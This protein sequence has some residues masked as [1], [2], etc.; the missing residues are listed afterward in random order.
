MGIGR[1]DVL[2]IA[3]LA[4]I[5][6]PEAEVEVFT[7]QFQRILDYVEKLRE[8]DTSGIEPTSHVGA[9]ADRLPARD[10]SVGSSLPVDDALAGAPDPGQGHFRVPKVL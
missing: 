2:R 8:V 1:N 5:E 3:E 7:G 9:A 6:I 4:N 10:D